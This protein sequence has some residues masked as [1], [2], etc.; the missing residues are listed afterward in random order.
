MN[1]FDGLTDEDLSSLLSQGQ[2]QGLG[3]GQQ[4]SLWSP[5]MDYMNQDYG[6]TPPEAPKPPNLF[7]PGDVSGFASYGMESPALPDPTQQVRG[8][9]GNI[10]GANVANKPDPFLA[11][12]KP[13]GLMAYL[14][15]LGA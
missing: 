5:D 14:S 6:P 12:K 3:M 9:M 2:D 10:I 8:I 4:A 1:I 11:P 7:Q 13:S 15:T